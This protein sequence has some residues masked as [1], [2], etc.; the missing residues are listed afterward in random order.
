MGLDTAGRN[1]AVTGD[2]AG[3]LDLNQLSGALGKARWWILVPSVIVGLGVTVAVNL[4]TPRYTAET[5]LILQSGETTFTRPVSN[6]SPEAAAGVLDERD[7]GSQA[8]VAASKD[9][10]RSAIEALKLRGNPEF[11]RYADPGAVRSLLMATGLMRAPTEVQR[12]EALIEAF[13]ERLLAFTTGLSRV[14]TIE[15]TSADPELAARGANTVATLFLEAQSESKKQAARAAG[16]WLL[17]TIEPLREKVAVAEARVEEFRA[18]KG[19]LASG[20]N[21]TLPQQQLSEMN[22]QLSTAKSA[23]A[24]AEAKA[25]LIKDALAAGRP[26]EISEIAN[27]ELVRKLSADRATLRAQV[28]LESRTLLPGHPRMKELTAQLANVEADIRA[29]AEKAV[30]TLENDSRVQGARVA[31]L[32][33]SLDDLKSRSARA[34]EDEVELRSLEREARTQREQLEAMMARYRDAVA[35]DAKDAVPADARIISTATPPATPSFPKKLP[36]ILV[37]TMSTLLVGAAIVVTREL[38]SGRAY[39]GAGQRMPAPLPVAPIGAEPVSAA[40]KDD[41][42]VETARAAVDGG[43]N[44][45]R[46]VAFAVPLADP[47]GISAAASATDVAEEA[48]EAPDMA[49]ADA[50]AV[51]AAIVAAIAASGDAGP[52]VLFVSDDRT[53]ARDNGYAIARDIA[54]LNRTVL[55]DLPGT[56]AAS[57]AAEIPGLGDVLAGR[58]G[59]V[60]V[61]HRDPASRL[62]LVAPGTPLLAEEQDWAAPLGRCLEALQGTYG[63][64][65]ACASSPAISPQAQAVAAAAAVLVL[66]DDT[67]ESYA[68]DA[69]TAAL[70]PGSPA[71]LVLRVERDGDRRASA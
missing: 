53:L 63:C 17:N 44:E 1:A 9:V 69:L 39:V 62:H 42:E 67:V 18:R 52:L 47:N 2:G 13:R 15:F 40:R 70:P 35:R 61:L 57:A 19:L 66:V 51:S 11:D 27:N 23:Q 71:P 38:L 24:D 56:A 32:T 14:M 49:E 31:Q 21:S 16:N 37:S 10:A 58:A 65:V 34:N 68:A 30:R 48:L 29:S 46:E 50:E 43:E 59:F 12:E 5:K 41:D 25:R 60:D 8:L 4:V 28:A 7:L 64:V 6:T 3:D 54:R 55:V 33:A 22:T 45:G 26:L 20:P 36:I